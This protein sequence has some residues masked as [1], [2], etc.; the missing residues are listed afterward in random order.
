M[1]LEVKDLKVEFHTA[2]KTSYA[3]RG[4]SFHMEKGE[5]LGIV[6]E[7]G[8]GKS[9]LGLTLMGLLPSYATYSGQ[10]FFEGK[11]LIPMSFEELRQTKGDEISVIFQ[12]PMAS[13]NPLIRVGRQVEEMLIIH[14]NDKDEKSKERVK[15]TKKERR[16]KVLEMFASVELPNPKEIYRRYPHELSGGM[17]QRVMI[18]MALICDPDLLIADEPT[19]ALDADVQD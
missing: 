12:E 11:D 3:V 6:G 1:L 5:I 10:V 19:T 2:E 13:L 7:S 4:V 15:L 9:T 8:S 17:Q 14:A 18:A 16:Q